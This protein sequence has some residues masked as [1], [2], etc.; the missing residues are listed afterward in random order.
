MGRR[1]TPLVSEGRIYFFSKEGTAFVVEAS[2]Q[3][4]V[5]SRV[6]IG[7]DIM[8]SPAAAGGSIFLRTRDNLYRIG[9][10]R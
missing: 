5:L 9:T 2:R 6:E 7:E 10:P 3:Y 4:K 8:A 1:A